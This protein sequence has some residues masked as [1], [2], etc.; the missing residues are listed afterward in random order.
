[1]KAEQREPSGLR[2]ACYDRGQ[3][4]WADLLEQGKCRGTVTAWRAVRVVS[5]LKHLEHGP[6]QREGELNLNH[7]CL[8]PFVRAG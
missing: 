5:H 4:T 8:A 1:M 7:W 3:Q 2:F 6:H